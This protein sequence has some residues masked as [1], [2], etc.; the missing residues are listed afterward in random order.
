MDKYIENVLRVLYVRMGVVACV[1]TS[2][3]YTDEEGS[4]KQLVDL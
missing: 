4:R 3:A 2:R 1:W